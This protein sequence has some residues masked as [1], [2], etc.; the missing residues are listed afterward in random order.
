MSTGMRNLWY[1]L[2]CTIY[3]PNKKQHNQIKELSS[4]FPTSAITL[5]TGRSYMYNMIQVWYMHY[6]THRWIIVQERHNSSALGME[7][8]RSC[9][10]PSTYCLRYWNIIWREEYDTIL[11]FCTSVIL[12]LSGENSCLN[13]KQHQPICWITS[14]ICFH[15][16]LQ[17]FK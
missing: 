14:V 16:T 10:N 6:R 13:A 11:K 1:I 3:S 15:E 5:N 2:Y 7:L 4:W 9:T 8:R 17:W 12:K